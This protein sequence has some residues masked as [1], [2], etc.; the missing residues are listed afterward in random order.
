M[1]NI[2]DTTA[3]TLT[4]LSGVSAIAHIATVYQPIVSLLAGLIA[5]I[6]GGLAAIYYIKKIYASNK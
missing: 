1:N 6:S 5:I 3:D 4:A 2:N